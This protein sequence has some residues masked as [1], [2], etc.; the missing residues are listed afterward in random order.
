MLSQGTPRSCELLEAFWPLHTLAWPPLGK[1]IWASLP[2]SPLSYSSRHCRLLKIR[3][4]VSA[5]TCF[6]HPLNGMLCHFS[7][8]SFT[9][10]TIILDIIFA[11]SS[12][13]FV[14]P[15]YHSFMFNSP[16]MLHKPACVCYL[17]GT[18]GNLNQGGRDA[19]RED[20]SS[21][22]LRCEHKFIQE[23]PL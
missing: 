11:K 3:H 10:P 2:H 8:F 18:T 22:L 7:S 13:T 15:S 6:D 12:L 20:S 16:K 19:S 21:C 5:K 1:N 23:I 17:S 4:I 9:N 14:T